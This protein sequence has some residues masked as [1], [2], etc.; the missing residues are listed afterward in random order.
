MK[1]PHEWATWDDYLSNWFH[2]W[3]TTPWQLYRWWTGG[4][5]EFQGSRLSKAYWCLRMF[6]A[7]RP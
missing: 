7:Y 3:I 2:Y 6:W 5:K 4:L 1:P